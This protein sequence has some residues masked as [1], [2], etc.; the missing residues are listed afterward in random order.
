MATKTKKAKSKVAKTKK[1]KKE[2]PEEITH[3]QD[4]LLEMA[5]AFVKTEAKTKGSPYRN[6][7]KV[8]EA[9]TAGKPARVVVKCTDPQVNGNGDS[10]CSNDREIAIQD[11]HQVKR[12][13]TCQKRQVQ[14][15]RNQLARQ[16]RSEL[17]KLRGNDTPTPAKKTKKA[18]GTKKVSKKSKKRSTKTVV[19]DTE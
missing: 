7:V 16:R 5:E 4:E 9:T 10:V 18:S 13:L 15:Y 8:V 3:S 6:I 1:V 12:C 19:E 17:Q 11:L 14:L 2:K